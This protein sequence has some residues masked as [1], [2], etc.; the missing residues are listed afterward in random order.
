MAIKLGETSFDR[1]SATRLSDWKKIPTA[2]IGDSL[3]RQHVM[4]TRISAILNRNMAGQAQTVGVIAGDNGAIHVVMDMIGPTDILV[5][6]GG[7]YLER[8]LW[9]GILNTRAIKS[10]VGGVVI[11]GAVRDILELKEMNLP[12][13]AAGVTPA[14]PHKGWGGQIGTSI[15]CG[16]VSVA[17]GDVIIGDA[18]G[19]VVVPLGQESRTYNSC[20]ERIA[21][22]DQI[23]EKIRQGKDLSEVFEKPKIE[24]L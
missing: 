24:R 11:D 3:N 1:L 17:P 22:E 12:V 10:G 16:G 19:V 14:G 7:G 8:A 20:L 2:I 4:A 21:F 23:L 18:D 9:G 6:D 5:V 13:Y 15:S